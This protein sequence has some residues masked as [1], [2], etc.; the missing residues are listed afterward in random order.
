MGRVPGS[1]AA[2]ILAF[3]LVA[4]FQVHL[5]ALY[6]WPLAPG[7]SPSPAA[8]RPALAPAGA[9]AEALPTSLPPHEIG[10]GFSNTRALLGQGPAG[11]AGL[12]EAAGLVYLW[13]S[14]ATTDA[15]FLVARGYWSG[16]DPVRSGRRGLARTA[17]FHG[18]LPRGRSLLAVQAVGW[19]LI[20]GGLALLAGRGRRDDERERLF[21]WLF[22]ASLASIALVYLVTRRGGFAH[23]VSLLAPLAAVPL[24]V[25][26][27]PAAAQPGPGPWAAAYAWRR[28]SRACCWSCRSTVWTR[29][30]R[31][32]SRSGSWAT[33][34]SAPAGRPF[35]LDLRDA[36]RA[37]R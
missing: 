21:A 26:P 13:L 35:E 14:M 10:T 12:R 6:L 25:P 30:S 11:T 28:P 27:A 9:L 1:R 5:P 34:R 16:F 17:A 7:P 15:S 24:L 37:R 20:L 22:A 4:G 23:Y 33:W 8:D 31:S 18:G 3:T 29:A 32:R 36:A 19:A 2:A